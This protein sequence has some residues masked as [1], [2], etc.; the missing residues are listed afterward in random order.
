MDI[1]I[2]KAE[3]KDIPAIHELV[4]E[5]AEY[6][7]GLHHVT[8]TPASYLVDFR[9]KVFDAFVAELDGQI[10]GMALYFLVFSTWRGRMLYLEDFVVRESERGNGVGAL[11]FKAFMEEAA[12]Q[13]VAL[14]KWQ[15]LKWNEPALNF[16]RKYDSVFDDEWLD[17]KIFL[18]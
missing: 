1:T 15:V 12:R 18:Q 4:R 2:R 10:L 7:K 6:E 13:E 14:V 16:Y 5:L 3:E 8:T 9:E 11:L 17:G